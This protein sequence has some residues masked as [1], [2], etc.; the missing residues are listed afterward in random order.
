MGD[1]CVIRVLAFVSIGEGRIGS[2][3]RG[4]YVYCIH[5]EQKVIKYVMERGSVVS[6][7]YN[8]RDE[9]VP[10]DVVKNSR[11]CCE[12]DSVCL[13]ERCEAR[14][15]GKQCTEGK[16]VESDRVDGCRKH[17]SMYYELRVKPGSIIMLEGR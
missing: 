3:D 12:S 4:I 7:L 8:I 13:Q 15:E 10:N 5:T 9:K 17:V 2:W 6:M 16:D 1:A 11:G 14:R